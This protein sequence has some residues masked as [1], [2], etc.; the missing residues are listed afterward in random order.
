MKKKIYERIKGIFRDNKEEHDDEW[1]NANIVMYIKDNTPMVETGTHARYR[2]K[3]D[4]EFCNKKHSVRDDTCD[5]FTPEEESGNSMKQGAKTITLQ[6]LYD[7]LK[8]ERE[9]MFEVMINISSR[10]YMKGLA[11]NFVK[12]SAVQ[13]SS[14]AITIEQCLRAYSQEE[15]VGGQDQWYCNECKEHRDIHKKLELFKMPK[16]LII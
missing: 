9:I 10:A 2:K 11:T 8:N 12:S 1:I 14:S 13:R 7:M 4:C 15:L 16:I 5:I 3:V 6:D